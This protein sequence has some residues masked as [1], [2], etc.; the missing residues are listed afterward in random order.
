MKSLIIPIA[1]KSSRFPNTRPKWLLTHPNGELMLTESLRGLDLDFFDVIYIALLKEHIE[2]YD[3]LNGIILSLSKIIKKEKIVISVLDNETKSQPE[4]VYETIIKNKINGF[5]GIKDCDNFF[6]CTFQN[7]NSIAIFDLNETNTINAKNK[8]YVIMDNNGR[9]VN[10]AEKRIISS[11]FSCG[12]YSFK[13]SNEYIKY[14]SLLKNESNLF[15]SHIILRMIIDGKTFIP[16]K[17]NNYID[18]GT[19]DDWIKFKDEYVTYFIDIDGVL[20]ENSAEYTKPFWGTTKP[21]SNNID[22]IKKLYDNGKSYICLTTSRKSEYK[23]ITENQLKKENIKYHNIIFD[24]L[25]SKRIIINDFSTTNPYKSCDS[26]NIERN[27]DNLN[28]YI[29]K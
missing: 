5:I 21:L 1:G 19:Y 24:L 15:I 8:S 23:N 12:F 4:T 14:Y 13:D 28:N 11:F 6:N 9:I 29:T 16:L 18:W 22:L 26:I 10:I 3:C 17:T 25:H 27:F 7:E 20:F 2:K